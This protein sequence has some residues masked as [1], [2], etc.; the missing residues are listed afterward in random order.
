[1]KENKSP[2]TENENKEQLKSEPTTQDVSEAREDRICQIDKELDDYNVKATSEEEISTIQSARDEECQ[3]QITDLED[4]LGIKLGTESTTMIRK[5]LVDSVIDGAKEDNETFDS[6]N[7]EKRFLRLYNNLELGENAEEIIQNAKKSVEEKDEDGSKTAMFESALGYYSSE[8]EKIAE[9]P[10]HHST[11]SYSLAKILKGGAL[12]SN[13]NNLTGE[14]ATTLRKKEKGEEDKEGKPT[15][16]AVGG[17]EQSEAVNLLYAKKNSQNPDLVLDSQEI[18]GVS[19]ED[20]LVKKVFSELPSLTSEEHET[21]TEAVKFIKKGRDI[22][23]EEVMSEKIKEVTERVYYYNEDHINKLIDEKRDEILQLADKNDSWSI[24]KRKEGEVV[25]QDLKERIEIYK[26]ETPEMQ[27][28]LDN[29]F[30]VI[31]SYEGKDLPEEDLNTLA[32]GLVS[33]RKTRK[34]IENSEM[35]QIQVPQNNI[36]QVKLFIAR[37]I[38]QPTISSEE[39]KALENIKIVPLEY[40][41]AKNI[42]NETK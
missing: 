37:R 28:E 6:L 5:N 15:S 10:V 34:V 30:P 3:A 12:D 24:K 31:I 33:E 7:N 4:G 29:A 21:V 14:H 17:Y 8:H 19:V 13:K 23:D 2:S 41:E 9:T 11:G 22:S 39:K 18:T 1:M 42:I 36:E 35:R 40:L 25:I 26:S 32:S 27:K 38:N 16:L 20:Q